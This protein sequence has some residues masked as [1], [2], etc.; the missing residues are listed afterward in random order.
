MKIFAVVSVLLLTVIG[1]GGRSPVVATTTPVASAPAP[2][3]P[4]NPP[5][6]VFLGDSI[7]YNW[8]QS[9]ASPDFAEFPQWT[10]KGIVGNDSG[11]MVDRFQTDVVDLHPDIV[12][13]LAGTNDV[14]P[15]WQLCDGMGTGYDGKN[16]D[17]CHNIAY[18]VT[19]AKLNGIKPILA[20]IPPWGCA[21]P[22]CA[23]ASNA[24]GSQDRYA[25]INALNGF[26]K[27]YG[28]QQGLVVV[29]YWSALVA[30]DQQHYQTA[31]TVDGV[32]PSPAGYVLMTP[33]VQAAISQAAAVN[34]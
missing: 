6:V 15:G 27:S 23:L 31:L 25:R 12:V 7:T 22:K 14:Y 9:W 10:D 8:G 2:I 3:A 4:V 20:T 5:N 19:Q 29:D 28:Q 32:H 21:D 13:I 30:P 1:C 17:T 18:M 33:L 16:W 26:V 11:E 24:D 34:Q